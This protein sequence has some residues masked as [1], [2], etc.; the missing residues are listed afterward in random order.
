MI[1]QDRFDETGAQPLALHSE[2]GQFLDGVLKPKIS[3]EFEA[4][5]DP[6]RGPQTDMLGAQ[7]T[8]SL[9]DSPILETL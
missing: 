4:I 6:R 2:K 9:N 3:P 8:M 5:D 1:E 7:I